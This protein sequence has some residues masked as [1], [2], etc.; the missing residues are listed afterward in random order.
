MATAEPAG[1]AETATREARPSEALKERATGRR[2]ALP[3]LP[4]RWAWPG[5]V[6][7][8]LGGLGLRLWGVRQGLPYAYNADEAD[9]FVPRAV[10]MF[11][12]DLNPHYFANPPGFTYVLHYLFALAYGSADG[13]R[14]AFSHE[15]TQVY[16]LARVAAAAL[17]VLA[18]WLLYLTG[19]RLLGRAAGLL[20]AAIEAVAFL[21]V[22][23]AH[24][25]LN[26]VPTLAPL[27]LSLLGSAGVLRKGRKR[28]YLLA[29]VGLGLACATKYT[30]GI[31]LLPLLAAAGARV[32]LPRIERKAAI[33]LAIGLALA[34]LAAFAAFFAANP[35]WL[36]D[37]KDFH[38][39]LVHQS[40]LSAEAQG[41]LGAPK[42]GG[43]VYYLWSLSWGLGWVPAIAALGGAIAIWRER[44]AL[45]FWLVPAP[46]LFLAFMGTQGRYFGRWLMP[47]LP[48]L[49]LLAAFFALWLA[50]RLAAV[51]PRGQ[52]SFG[53]AAAALIAAL[54]LAQGVVYGVHAGT[55]LARADTRNITREWML[56]NVPHRARIVAEP[57]SPDSWA[58]E[59]PGSVPPSENPGVWRKYP[60]LV[61]RIS[62]SGALEEDAH[63]VVGI[64]SY[65]RTLSPALL[66]YYVHH[67]YCWVISG[68][69]QSGRAFADPHEV[70]LAVAYYRALERQGEVVFRASPYGQ[71]E[72][73][74]PFGF[75]WS[76]DY[77]PLAY[78]RP[79]PYVTIYRLH[80]GKCR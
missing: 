53:A 22:F 33:A 60:D 37:Y 8:L 72:G 48:L 6:L 49:C 41:K 10:E 78:H 34:A 15:P 31:A 43:L 52:I 46:L 80:G 3:E 28:D 51:L 74:V 40:T 30:A 1:P 5:L 59:H 70:P 32:G 16:T 77:Y 36:L 68:S 55:V 71:G 63:R 61:S 44:A 23:Y 54:L 39:E 57:I 29:G 7:V 27:T 11:G 21:P 47:I 35:F 2:L 4:R 14:H 17:G 9:H 65:V 25:A 64:E 18:L 75:D 67:E 19:A 20:A 24:L 12:H 13:V 50:A 76:F 42:Q 56:A 26:D 62:P 69:T 45:G 66:A 38:A 73:P 79:G 58:R